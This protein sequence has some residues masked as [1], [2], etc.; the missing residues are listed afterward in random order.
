MSGFFHNDCVKRMSAHRLHCKVTDGHFATIF[1]SKVQGSGFTV[2]KFKVDWI[3]ALCP[4][5]K[6]TR[7][8]IWTFERWTLNL[9]TLAPY[10]SHLSWWMQMPICPSV[11]NKNPLTRHTCF[12][13]WSGYNE[14]IWYFNIGHSGLQPGKRP[15]QRTG[16]GGFIYRRC[17][18][19]ILRGIYV[20]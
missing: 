4:N 16:Q 10:L 6:T 1:G 5:D 9:S 11:K 20:L 7:A 12:V 2:Q 14:S 17:L 3:A 15:F 19:R 13:T 8:K 18:E